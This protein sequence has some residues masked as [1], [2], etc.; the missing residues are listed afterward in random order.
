MSKPFSLVSYTLFVFVLTFSFVTWGK[1]SQSGVKSPK[2][3]NLP[4][5]PETTTLPVPP[6]S[7]C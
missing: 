3:D 6:S 2:P 7:V 4:T 1:S 5:N